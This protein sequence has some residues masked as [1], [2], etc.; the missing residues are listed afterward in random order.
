MFYLISFDISDDGERTKVGKALENH[1]ERVQKSVFE[2][3]DLTE[4]A[5][6]KLKADIEDRIDHA[7]DSVRYYP[8][9]GACK[10]KVEYSGTGR[11]P[12]AGK[13]RII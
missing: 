12:A 9:C 4:E 13:F 2:C 7:G 6:L 11:E 5:L 10:E 8:L 1:G 3:P